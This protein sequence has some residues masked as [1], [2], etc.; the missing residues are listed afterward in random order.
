MG[1]ILGHVFMCVAIL[2]FGVILLLVNSV[3]NCAGF[4][5]AGA[6]SFSC[7]SIDPGDPTP[8]HCPKN[9]L[10]NAVIYDSLLN[11]CRNLMS[12]RRVLI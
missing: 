1:H 3:F 6:I 8:W 10:E 9:P 5:H 11:S 7:G 12:V 4:V 2:A